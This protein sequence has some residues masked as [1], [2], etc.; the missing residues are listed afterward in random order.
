MFERL[1]KQGRATVTASRQGAADLG[2]GF[3]GTEHLLRAAHPRATGW[4]EPHS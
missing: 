1:T 4:A 2:H 3:V